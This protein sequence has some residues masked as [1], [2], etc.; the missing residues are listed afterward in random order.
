[1]AGIGSKT[2]HSIM[3]LLNPMH[4]AYTHSST[5]SSHFC[6]PHN[7][8]ALQKSFHQSFYSYCIFTAFSPLSIPQVLYTIYGRQKKIF[9]SI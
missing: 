4:I 6:R 9:I 7:S 3:Y 8:I 2:L 5:F 1:M